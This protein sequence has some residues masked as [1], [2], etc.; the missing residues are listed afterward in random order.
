MVETVSEVLANAIANADIDNWPEH[1]HHE[2]YPTDDDSVAVEDP[3]GEDLVSDME[4]AW[5]DHQYYSSAAEEQ[6]EAWEDSPYY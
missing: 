2:N 5:E 1:P 3:I 6:D 4:V